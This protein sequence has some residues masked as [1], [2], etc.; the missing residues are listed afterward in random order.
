MPVIV[1]SVMLV[2]VGVMLAGTAK[3]FAMLLVGRSI[4]GLGSGGTY[5]CQAL[6]WMLV[7]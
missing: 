3:S 5:T 7:Y 2:F 1:A 6:L 4:Q